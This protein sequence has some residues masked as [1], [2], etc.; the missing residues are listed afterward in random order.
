MAKL[1]NS[2]LLDPRPSAAT[3]ADPVPGAVC[4]PLTEL[5]ERVSELPPPGAPVDVLDVGPAAAAV[6]DW[7]G[8]RGRSAT[9]CPFPPGRRPELADVRCRLWRP[10]PF[11][12]AVLASV[13]PGRLC[14]LGCGVGRDAV[15]A[16]ALGWKVIGVDHLPDAI[17]RARQLADRYLDDGGRIDWVVADID[18]AELPVGAGFDCVLSVRCWQPGL[19]ERMAA[20]LC[21]GGLAVVVAFSAEHRARHGKPA[22]PTR[23]LDPEQA[24]E[25]LAPLQVERLSIDNSPND[26]PHAVRLVARKPV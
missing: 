1:V 18:A 10:D 22:D 19:T 4:I 13:S 11:V 17:A 6:V 14:D 8:E 5:A 9:L 21:P 2:T 3:Q 16:A 26:G 23:V 12:A 25:Q 24:A 15:F 20:L 7:L